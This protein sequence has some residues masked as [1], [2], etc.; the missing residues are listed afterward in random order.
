MIRSALPIAFVL[1]AGCA[2][3]EEANLMPTDSG[4]SGRVAEQVRPERADEEPALGAW[5][6]TIQDTQRALE[7]G[8]QGAPPLFSLACD[9]RRGLVLQRHG[10]QAAGDLPVMTLSIGSETRR[11]AVTGGDG[12]IPMLR[13]SL[14]P[15][16]Q[17]AASL[18]HAAGPITIRIG[19]TPPL[20][21]PPSPLIGTYIGQCESGA[22]A[23][24]V[25]AADAAA[26]ANVAGAGD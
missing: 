6:D 5:R 25:A 3:S 19:E 21:L 7:F 26:P 13:A 17:A 2:R 4:G 10:I 8:P 18:S 9:G 16:D 20:I 14:S 12:P 24:P 1:L 23:A 22:L 11:L 15:S